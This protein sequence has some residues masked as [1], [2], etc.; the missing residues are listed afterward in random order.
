ME[1]GGRRGDMKAESRNSN[2]TEMEEGGQMPAIA[3]LIADRWMWL[4]DRLI[5]C[6]VQVKLSSW[7]GMNN[8]LSSSL[9]SSFRSSKIEPSHIHSVFFLHKS[10]QE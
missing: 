6:L 5:A 7:S 4:S 10:N 8:A 9:T 3:D 1:E 2:T